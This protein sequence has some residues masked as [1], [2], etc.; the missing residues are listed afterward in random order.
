MGMLLYFYE[1]ISFVEGDKSNLKFRALNLI[2]DCLRE[3][4]GDRLIAIMLF[5]SRARGDFRVDNDYDIFVLVSDYISGP[6]EDYFNAYKALRPFRNRFI[7]DTT[8]VL[9][10]IDDLERS[11]SSSLVLN[12]LMDGIIVYDKDNTL[13]KIRKKLLRKLRSLG[14]KRVKTNIGYVWHVPPAIKVPF[15]VSINLRDP[16]S[17]K[18]RLQLARKHFDEARKA[19]QAEALIA[20]THEAQ[21]SIENPAKA[22]IAIFKPPMWIHNPA[23]E[24]RELVAEGRIPSDVRDAVLRLAEIAEEVAPHYALSS[25][26]DVRR[27]VTPRYIYNK[28]IVESLVNLAKEALEIVVRLLTVLV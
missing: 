28:E 9:I 3:V 18:Y 4:F 11:L 26:G 27:E 10:S 22:V 16:P 23:P 1:D 2:V 25:Y 12:A 17:Y 15:K 5:G 6:I 7:L 24:L 19:L 8:V 13:A 21:L 20:A 14:V